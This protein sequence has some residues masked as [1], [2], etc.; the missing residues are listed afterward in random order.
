MK[1]PF[2]LIVLFFLSPLGVH[3]DYASD[4]REQ[5]QQ[6]QSRSGG[7][8]GFDYFHDMGIMARKA[9]EAELTDLTTETI[10]SLLLKKMDDYVQAEVKALNELYVTDRYTA[11]RR[12]QELNQFK[13]FYQPT[14]DY[15][16]TTGGQAIHSDMIRFRAD[17][18]EAFKKPCSNENIISGLQ[19]VLKAGLFITKTPEEI[20]ALQAL[21]PK[22]ECCLAF[23]PE[24]YFGDTQDF[25]STYEQG[26]LTVEARLKLQ[27]SRRDYSDAKWVGDW[28]QRFDGRDGTGEATAQAIL[29]Y[30][31]GRDTAD[32]LILASR[33]TSV[34][35]INFPV[36]LVG[37]TR[38]LE[39][40][41]KPVAPRVLF[42]GGKTALMTGCKDAGK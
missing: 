9:D 21:P 17:A 29:K 42:T 40:Q 1:T 5:I 18:L 39:V 37:E 32:L 13:R 23:A 8:L 3:A 7:K 10:K 12:L 35:R 30:T 38:T 11:S 36:S 26:K 27:S 28:I 22:I 34:G 16:G 2:L 33:V 15:L 24:L 19:A 25:K 4:L 41:G 14:E 20:K 31:K 6:I